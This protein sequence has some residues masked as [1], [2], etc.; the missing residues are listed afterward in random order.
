MGR[1]GSETQ[2]QDAANLSLLPGITPEAVESEE[3]PRVQV[4]RHRALVFGVFIVS[5]VAFLYFVLPRLTGFGKTWDRIDTGDPAWL[6]LAVGFEILAYSS[7]VALFRSVFARGSTRI[8]WRQSYQITLAGLMATRLFA[9]AGAGGVLLMAWALRR[10]GMARRVVARRM[11][12]FLT[13]LYTVYMAAFVVDG[14]GLRTGLFPGGGAFAITVVPAIVGGVLIGLML[15][16]SLIPD[17]IEERLERRGQR[18]GR[19]GHWLARVVAVPAFAA[20]AVRTALSIPRNRDLGAFGAVTWWGFDIAVLWA[21][22][23][24]FGHPPPYAVIVMAYFVGMLGNLLPLPGGVGGVDGGMIGALIAFNV[25]SG[26]AVVA[27]LAYRAIAFWL[28]IAPG[29]VAY[30]ALR[31]SIHRWQGETPDATAGTSRPATA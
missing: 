28:P 31:R 5:V 9:A 8:G 11:L 18:S 27:V 19:V 4:T 7:Y 23:H 2:R 24:A 15:L 14:I 3:M 10:S 29:A 6:G 1:E 25:D 20:S 12:A 26:L 22:F 21:S 30:F 13:M 16:V 17:G